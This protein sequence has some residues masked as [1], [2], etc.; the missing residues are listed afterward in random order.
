MITA[1]DAGLGGHM[2]HQIA[3][4]CCP[5]NSFPVIQPSPA[6]CYAHRSQAC[7]LAA[8]ETAHLIAPFAQHAHDRPAQ[9][10]AAT[11]NQD[12]HASHF[13]AQTA[14]FSRK[15]SAL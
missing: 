4:V 8:R 6:L 9:K 3:S 7:I 1:P 14:S 5:G 2:K 10:A 13:S 11:V 12:L 15:I